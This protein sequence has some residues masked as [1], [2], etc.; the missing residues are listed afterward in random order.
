MSYNSHVGLTT[1]VNL[2]DAIRTPKYHLQGG[3]DRKCCL[4]ASADCLRQRPALQIVFGRFYLTADRS[5]VGITGEGEGQPLSLG[6]VLRHA[7]KVAKEA[8]LDERLPGTGDTVTGLLLKAPSFLSGMARC[9]SSVLG[10]GV[11][12]LG[13]KGFSSKARQNKSRVFYG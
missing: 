5:L 12:D 4:L 10:L 3:C 2:G 11:K 1:G 13:V 7:A 6:T 9:C 8:P